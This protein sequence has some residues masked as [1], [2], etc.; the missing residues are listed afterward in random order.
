MYVDTPSANEDKGLD[1]PTPKDDDPEG[2]KLL[3]I[4]DPLEQAAK[5]LAPLRTLAAENIDVW[6]AVYDVSIRRS[7]QD[8]HVTYH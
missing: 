6:I 3:A 5:L 2:L 8:H 1:P 7:K 4:T